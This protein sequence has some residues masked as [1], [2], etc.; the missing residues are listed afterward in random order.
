M[1]TSSI[2]VGNLYEV[3][4]GHNVTVVKIKAINEKTGGWT[5][6]TSKGKR[7][8]IAD[9]KRFVKEVM[10]KKEKAVADKSAPAKGKTAVKKPTLT[11]V[12][13]SKVVALIPKGRRATSTVHDLDDQSKHL[14]PK[15]RGQM[16]ALSAA[17]RVLKEAVKPLGV[18]EI[19]ETALVKQYCDIG[20]K[21][22]FNT[23]NGGIRKEITHKGEASRFVWVSAGLFAT[24]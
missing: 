13:K 21:T 7:M 14:G 5:C 4:S 18:R 20:G 17:H 6:E 16:S 9:S 12:V 3:K 24:R 11:E 1:K 15:P 23:I 2:K 8:N 10:P 22:P 19:L